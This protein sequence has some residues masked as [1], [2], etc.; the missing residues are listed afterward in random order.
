MK[1]MKQMKYHSNF[2][3]YKR[4]LSNNSTKNIDIE[5]INPNYSNVLNKDNLKETNDIKDYIF[6]INKYIMKNKIEYEISGSYYF[7]KYFTHLDLL[8]VLDK[9]RELYTGKENID[10]YCENRIIDF[11]LLRHDK[12]NL[13]KYQY[14]LYLDIINNSKISRIESVKNFIF[15]LLNS[16]NFHYITLI[17]YEIM[18]LNNTNNYYLYINNL[19]D[20]YVKD[21]KESLSKYEFIDTNII[22]IILTLGFIEIN[23]NEI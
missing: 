6:Y 2:K 9:I 10:E 12:I 5:Y 14:K 1:Q 19:N 16:S 22:E 23:L 3:L 20:N 8:F 17:N 15:L 18:K 11:H 7:K 13:N 21:L 4:Y